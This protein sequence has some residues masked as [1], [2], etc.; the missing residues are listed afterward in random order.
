[1]DKI[2]DIVDEIVTIKKGSVG[3]GL[4]GSAVIQDKVTDMLDVEG[5]IRQADPEF[6]ETQLA[7]ASGSEEIA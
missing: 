6:Y 2:I 1:M 3:N 4:L 7:V 5:I